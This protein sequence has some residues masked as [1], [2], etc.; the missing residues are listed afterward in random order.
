MKLFLSILLIAQVSLASSG[1][2]AEKGNGGDYVLCEKGRA[3]FL[4][5]YEAIYRYKLSPSLPKVAIFNGSD[6]DGVQRLTKSLKVVLQ[7]I[8]KFDP[9]RA[10]VYLSWADDLVEQID[11]SV[12]SPQRIAD[13]GRRLPILARCDFFQ[14]INQWQ[15]PNY[16]LPILT[17]NT[18]LWAN[19]SSEQKLTALIHEILLRELREKQS[20][21]K[22]TENL[23]RFC[24]YLISR[25]FDQLEKFQ[26][27][28]L[29]RDMLNN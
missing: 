27:K 9:I 21:I 3:Y 13:E 1:D 20:S 18:R 15:S 10:Q 6:Q 2:W 22:N 11:F 23:R 14:L 25:E 16:K 19:L 26:Y 4:D 29:L 24:A 17:I 8:S 28:K 12:N 5:Y 7:K